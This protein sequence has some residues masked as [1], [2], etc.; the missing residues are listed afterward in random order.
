[1]R[2]RTNKKQKEIDSLIGFLML[3]SGLV[4]WYTA[5]T[6]KGVGIAVGICFG[7]ILL[8]TLWQSLRFK[9][10][11]QQSGMTEIDKMTGIEFEEYLGT[12]FKNQGYHVTYTPTTGDYGADLIL[13]K[14]KEVI[15]VQAKRYNQT[16]GV[17]AVQEVIPAIMMYKATS[18]WVITNS[19]YTKQA[20]TLAKSN[21]VRMIGRD[22]LI[23][24]SL[25]FRREPK[26]ERDADVKPADLIAATIQED[27]VQISNDEL[28]QRLKS[29]RS[30][31]AKDAGLKAYHV[32][33]NK[34]LD[35]LVAK[36][37]LTI[38]DLQGIDG[39][40]QKRINAYG[41]EL[42]MVINRKE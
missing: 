39:L 4:G 28:I 30:K 37:P 17:K 19:T 35:E 41:A 33:T 36:R 25:T 34:T 32:F 3:V 29:Y 20:L 7:I 8:F 1:M 16:V 11:M 24:M 31:T 26:E 5:G 23:K 13:K 22:E 14:D 2:N 12:L 10:R 18:A 38:N 21:H 6:L 27:S 9:K 15:V 40:G 42:V